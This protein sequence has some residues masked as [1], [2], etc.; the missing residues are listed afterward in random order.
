MEDRR[1]SKADWRRI[2]AA[3]VGALL[4][5]A[6]PIFW[7]ISVILSEEGW[8]TN[9]PLRISGTV[10]AGMIVITGLLAFPHGESRGAGRIFWVLIGITAALLVAWFI[11]HSACSSCGTP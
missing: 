5:V 11:A 10:V 7:F 8:E 9:E 1:A 3:V 4:L 2:L 6:A